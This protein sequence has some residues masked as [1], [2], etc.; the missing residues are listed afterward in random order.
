MLLK[1]FVEQEI[2]VYCKK[3]DENS[4]QVAERYS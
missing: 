2:R 4:L 3:K 1:D